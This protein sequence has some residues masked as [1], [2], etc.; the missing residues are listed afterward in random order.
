M[1]SCGP[2]FARH[3]SRVTYCMHA[4]KCHI[5]P[6][7][8]VYRSLRITTTSVNIDISYF[9]TLKMS[10]SNTDAPGLIGS[11][12]KYV[13]GAAQVRLMRSTHCHAELILATGDYWFRHRKPAMAE[14]RR[15][16]QSRRREGDARGHPE[17]RHFIRLR[18]G[19]GDGR[20]GRWL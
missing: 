18:Q 20:Q 6:H 1:A 16:H 4:F 2:T 5:T 3:Y 14:Q 8:L 7:R 11:H 13:N 12:A 10:S 19:R 17:P 15:L 9:T